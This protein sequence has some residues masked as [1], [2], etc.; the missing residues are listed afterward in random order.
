VIDESG[1]RIRSAEGSEQA[2]LAV[3]GLSILD[4]PMAAVPMTRLAWFFSP[5][6]RPAVPATP[7]SAWLMSVLPDAGSF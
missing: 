7:A 5:D 6:G 3:Q 4:E 1:L 2:L